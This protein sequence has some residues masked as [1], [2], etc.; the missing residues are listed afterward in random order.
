MIQDIQ[1]Y[2]QNFPDGTDVAISQVD[3]TKVDARILKRLINMQAQRIVN[4]NGNVGFT[5]AQAGTEQVGTKLTVHFDAKLAF[6]YVELPS[7]LQVTNIKGLNVVWNG[8]T[9]GITGA[10]LVPLGN[11]NTHVTV[12]ASKFG[13]SVPITMEVDAGGKPVHTP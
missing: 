10:D 9:V 4:K 6:D 13:I 8:L 2:I 11:G 3:P 5:F 7:L 12:A 1:R